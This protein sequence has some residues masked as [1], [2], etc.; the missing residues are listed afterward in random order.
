MELQN[1][2]NDI[3]EELESPSINRQRSRY[4]KNY[5][6]ELLEYQSNH[7][8]ETA[9]PTHLELYCDLNPGAPEC[10]IFDD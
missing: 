9:V 6:S 3:C 4:L 7:P 2:I 10:R 5:L 8:E 1:L